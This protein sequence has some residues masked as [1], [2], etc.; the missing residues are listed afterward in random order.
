[1]TAASIRNTDGPA[2][3]EPLTCAERDEALAFL[4]ERPVHTVI[5]AGL[6]REHGA[7]VPSPEGRFY[8]C[9]GRRG[10]L[11]GVALVGR[12]TMF[13]ARTAG[14]ISAFAGL[15]RRCPSVRMIMGEAGE[16][17]AFW[18]HYSGGGLA[19]RLR[20]REF[21]YEFSKASA[22]GAGVGGLRQAT[23]E[24]LEQVVAAHAGMVLEETGVNPLA[25]DAEGFRLRC[26][27]RVGRGKVWALIERGELVFKADVVTETPEAAYIEGVWVNPRHRHKGYGRRCWDALSRALLD[28]A[29]AFCGFVNA[30]NGAALNFYAMVGGAPR[31]D[32]Q[33]VYV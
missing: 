33:K 26:A 14:A 3:A 7:G 19:P 23:L 6:M 27:Q 25:E 22:G 10:R 11:E 18:K 12:A 9:R 2:Q 16:L 29:P 31:G 15:A 17:D 1:M 8:A 13:E 4:G 28:R 20:C 24:D 32:Y 5:M 30:E 21:L